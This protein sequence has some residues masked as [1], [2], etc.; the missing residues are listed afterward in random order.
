ME[1]E[2]V[3]L[4]TSQTLVSICRTER[5][6]EVIDRTWMIASRTRPGGYLASCSAMRKMLDVATSSIGTVPL[7]TT[8]LAF[9][10]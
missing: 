9:F 1:E 2:G 4:I 6:V 8:G 7:G 3:G 5:G 10:C